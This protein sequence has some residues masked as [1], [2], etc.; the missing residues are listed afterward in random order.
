[1][2]KIH[3]ISIEIKSNGENEIF[4]WDYELLLKTD[5]YMCLRRNEDLTLLQR[6]KENNSI[7]ICIEDINIWFHDWKHSGYKTIHCSLYTI[8]NLNKAIEKMKKKI[9]SYIHKE[10]DWLFGRDIVN[11]INSIQLEGVEN[12]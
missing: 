11:R 12:G 10:Y 9:I 8:G 2:E 1:M 3:Y 6:K 4:A 5:N 7:Y